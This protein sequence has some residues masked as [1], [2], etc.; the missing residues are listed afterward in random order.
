M[1]DRGRR[2]IDHWV[3]E[4]IDAGP[5][6]LEG[7]TG[8]ARR[9][10]A[11]LIVVAEAQG[12]SRSEIEEGVG[13]PRR[14][15]AREPSRLCLSRRAQRAAKGLLSRTTSSRNTPAR[16]LRSAERKRRRSNGR[17]P[18]STP[19]TSRASELPIGAI[20]TTGVGLERPAGARPLA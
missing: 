7:D 10:A 13:R 11:E 12:V 19:P 18:I 8:E 17:K 16:R 2:F 6:H 9:K 5:Y 4:H 14:F 15:Q 1:N 3:S 20:Q